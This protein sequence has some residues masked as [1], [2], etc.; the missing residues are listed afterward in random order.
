[1]AD[2]YIGTSGSRTAWVGYTHPGSQTLG[3]S[4]GMISPRGCAEGLDVR[5]HF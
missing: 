4:S 1:M 3:V 5:G 2:W